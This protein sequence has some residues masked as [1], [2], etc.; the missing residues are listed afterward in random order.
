MAGLIYWYRGG[1]LIQ[2]NQYMRVLHLSLT[3]PAARR[4]VGLAVGAAVWGGASL[5][6]TV[7][8]RHSTT[9][10]VLAAVTLADTAGDLAF[11]L[12]DLRRETERSLRMYMMLAAVTSCVT[13]AIGACILVRCS[14]SLSTSVTPKRASSPLLTHPRPDLYA[15]SRSLLRL[16]SPSLSSSERPP[17]GHV[18]RPP[19][20]ASITCGQPLTANHT[21]TQYRTMAAE[22][23]ASSFFR[24]WVR[25]HR[26]VTLAIMLVAVPNVE[27]LTL[28][29][30]LLHPA[31]DVRWLDSPT[32][33]RKLASLGFLSLLQNLPQVCAL[34]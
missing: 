18:S 17:C 29:S 5:A 22:A 16:T 31:L 15:H 33:E 30:S 25:G 19:V 34:Q 27:V 32:A 23:H 24:E 1:P 10:A 21:F 28:A 4:Q 9:A 7:R 3:S 14:P 8:R 11:I 20:S 2:L 13:L 26:L 12:C 6:D